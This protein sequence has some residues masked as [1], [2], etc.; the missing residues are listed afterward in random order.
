MVGKKTWNSTQ[1][2]KGYSTVATPK[3][4][5]AWESS[6]HSGGAK[7]NVKG[8]KGSKAPAESKPVAGR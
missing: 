4:T 2:S 5:P 7:Q 8:K 3:F 1:A 6:F